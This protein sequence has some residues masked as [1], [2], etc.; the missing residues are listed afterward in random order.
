MP[1]HSITFH[2]MEALC[3]YRIP[4]LN[5]LQVITTELN[6]HVEISNIYE[7]IPDVF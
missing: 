4:H 1:V 2:T 3:A 6:M 7:N 5:N